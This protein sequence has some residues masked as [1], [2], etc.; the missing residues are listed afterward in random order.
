MSSNGKQARGPSKRPHR[1]DKVIAS[2]V[3]LPGLAVPLASAIIESTDDAILSVALDGTISS[4][5]PGAERLYG[6]R[7]EEGVGQ[8]LALLVPDDMPGELPKILEHI[9]LGSRIDHY[10]TVRRHKDGSRVDVSLGLS[11]LRPGDSETTGAVI[12]ARDIRERR[13]AAAEQE[14]TSRYFQSLLESTGEGIYGLDTEGSC[15]F[16]NDAAARLLGYT[17]EELLG[18]NMHQLAHHSR[19]DGPPYSAA[20]C[21]IF[22]AF[23]HGDP[24]RIDKSFVLDVLRDE[25]DAV[26]VRSIIDLAHNLSRIT[27]AE[28]VETEDIWTALAALGCDVA[29]GYYMGK[30]MLARDL[31]K[32]LGESQFGFN[33]QASDANACLRYSSSNT[34]QR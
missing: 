24:C 26:I 21:P 27:V 7:A 33:G 2:R 1:E 19:P 5:N 6:Y 22:R 29:Q 30:P 11:P 12:I 3:P 8:P 9:R 32:W 10:E 16:V 23:R 28:G 25:N 20:D 15:T 31:E 13:R 14:R 4:W 34:A 17:R 18:R